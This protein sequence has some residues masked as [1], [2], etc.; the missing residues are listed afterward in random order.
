MDIENNKNIWV[1]NLSKTPLTNAQEKVLSCGPNFTIVPRVPPVVEYVV[2]IEKACQQL[3]QGE[4]E[5][6]RGE[7]KTIIKKIHPPRPNISK[8]EYQALQQL[9][10]DNTR[11]ILTADKGVCLVVMDKND[12]MK[13]SEELLSKST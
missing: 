7:V 1:R 3:K 5:E 6:L 10:K 4:A 2:A 9:K 8:E 13:K 11:M 12:Y